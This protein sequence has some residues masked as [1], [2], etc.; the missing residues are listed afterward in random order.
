MRA[1]VRLMFGESPNLNDAEQVAE[2]AYAT[3]WA[4]GKP[5]AVTRLPDGLEVPLPDPRPAV[6]AHLPTGGL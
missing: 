6:L 1:A 2:I 3:V 5:L 4:A